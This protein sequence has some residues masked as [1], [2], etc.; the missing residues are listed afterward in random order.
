MVLRKETGGYFVKLYERPEL[1]KL[2]YHL[3]GHMKGRTEEAY[4]TGLRRQYLPVSVR[5]GYAPR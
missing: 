4:L 5:T 2:A 1:D 3:P